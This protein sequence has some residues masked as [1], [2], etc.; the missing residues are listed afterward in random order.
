[1]N[2]TDCL[3]KTRRRTNKLHH[4]RYFTPQSNAT[5]RAEYETSRTLKFFEHKRIYNPRATRSPKNQYFESAAKGSRY[6]L[7]YL[8]IRITTSL[9]LLRAKA[10][11]D[12]I[13]CYTEAVN[14]WL[15]DINSR[16][17][18]III[19]IIIIIITT[20]TTTTIVVVVLVVVI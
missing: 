4:I 12:C 11:T 20:T 3:H 16:H 10:D 18:I 13:F 15:H 1:M 9:R 14:D 17:A 6:T 19:I 2:H 5:V 8:T 7:F